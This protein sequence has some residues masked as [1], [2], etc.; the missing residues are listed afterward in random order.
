MNRREWVLSV[1]FAVFVCFKIAEAALQ[2]ESWPASNVSMFSGLRPRQFVPLRSRLQ[3]AR[4]AHSLQLEHSDFA[5]T[6]DEFSSRLH[7]DGAVGV[8]CGKLVA[9]YNRAVKDPSLRV[10][11]AVVVVEPVARPGLWNDVVGW[12]V[13][14]LVPSEG[15]EKRE[16]RR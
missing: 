2:M 13:P 11:D 10:S 7:P 14:C 12:K 8:R 1:F 9:S 4:G 5:L 16:P 3:A 15:A 6:E